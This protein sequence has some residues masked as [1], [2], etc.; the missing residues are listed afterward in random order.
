MIRV[1]RRALARMRTIWRLSCC[2]MH[3]ATARELF[4]LFSPQE[5]PQQISHIAANP[6]LSGRF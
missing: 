2:F 1:W 5:E 3:Q 4:S 6:L